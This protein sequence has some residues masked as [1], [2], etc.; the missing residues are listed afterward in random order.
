MQLIEI[1][2]T[3]KLYVDLDGVLV[4]FDKG[5]EQIGFPRHVVETDRKAK[6]KFWQTVGAMAA[7]GQPFWGA[8]D[9]MADAMQLWNYVKKYSPE[10]LSATGHVGNA[11]AEKH[12]WVKHHLG[13][14]P[15]HLVK[16][17][18]DKAQFATAT[19]ILIDD[20]TKS[21]EPWL[22]AGGIGILHVTAAK[23]I[24]Q[25]KELGL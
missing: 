23:T 20:R 2:Q 16:N 10:I 5:M 9:P 13:N 18:K 11:V 25:L 19:S 17:S 8:M 12:E 4:D 3:Y 15:T 24:E 14:V 6:A 1:Q 21:I 7:K 22:A